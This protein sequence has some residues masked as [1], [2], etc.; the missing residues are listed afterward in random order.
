MGVNL[1][2]GEG[3]SLKD[4]FGVTVSEGKVALTWFNNYSGTVIRTPTS[5][6]IFDPVEIRLTDVPQADVIVITH[7]HHDHFEADFTRTLQ[8]Q[9]GAVVVT[10]PFVA[11][12]LVRVPS[13][14]LK[15]VSAGESV[16]VGEVRLEAG[17]SDH[18]G[19]QSLT[20]MITA[21]NISIFHSSDSRPHPRMKRIREKAAPD[22]ALCT[23]DIAPGTSP[24]SG[25]E[26]A[27]LVRP[28]I[29]IPY[30]TSREGPLREFAAILA[31]EAPEI[32]T[33][34]LRRFE[35][36]EYPE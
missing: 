7:E 17:R 5:T 23:V 34:I 9:T 15:V 33:R 26:I 10:T 6:L 31:R 4:I 20:F 35:V 13:D 14:K 32:R 36:Y 28:R 27:K 11:G 2:L 18:P 24:R 22:I 25:A 8:K 3:M 29:A 30:H 21:N 1:V 16:T 12:Q 19:S